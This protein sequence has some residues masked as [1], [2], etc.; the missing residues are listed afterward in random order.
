MG[1]IVNKS[2]VI[3]DKDCVELLSYFLRIVEYGY[4]ETDTTKDN[5]ERFAHLHRFNY[6]I[7]GNP[8]YDYKGQRV[9]L[10]PGT[11]VYLGPNE[12]LGVD[13]GNM[14]HLYF[15]NFELGA[16]DKFEKFY[17]F[18]NSLFQYNHVHDDDDVLKRFF[19]AIQ[20]AGESKLRAN[21]LEIHNIFEN[22]FIHLIRKSKQSHIHTENENVKGTDGLYNSAI[23][24]INTNI[25]KN[26]KV[27]DIAESLHIS[28][29]YLYKIFV[30]KTG[31]SPSDFILKFR[32][33]VAKG[34]LE[35]TALPVSDIASMLGYNSNAFFSHVFKNYTGVTPAQYRKNSKN[36]GTDS[37]S[38]IRHNENI[39]SDI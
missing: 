23:R 38:I 9:E 33:D 35:N 11:I 15:I 1:T 2:K 29:N 10:E 3:F 14:V 30:E 13:E 26:P 27:S 7:S 32:M 28:E 8:Y 16:A 34:N 5:G 20:K 19:E 12:R 17:S 36:S 37:H 24:Y 22:L 31:M 6:I 21:G 25:H 39:Q 18:M 4:V